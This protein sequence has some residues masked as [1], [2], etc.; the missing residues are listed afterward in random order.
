MEE[1]SFII[2]YSILW[3]KEKLKWV[4]EEWYIRFCGFFVFLLL[5]RRKVYINLNNL[6]MILFLFRGLKKR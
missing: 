4:R 2:K 1:R 3:Y 5:V 6:V